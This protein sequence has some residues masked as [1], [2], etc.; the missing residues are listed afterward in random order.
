MDHKLS[1]LK[2]GRNTRVIRCE[3]FD[4]IRNFLSINNASELQVK[5]IFKKLVDNER[6]PTDLTLSNELYTNPINQRDSTQ[7]IFIF[8]GISLDLTREKTVDKIRCAHEYIRP[9]HTWSILGSGFQG[10]RNNNYQPF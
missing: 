7:W 9:F 6:I 8:T 4:E 2:F 3:R 10:R 5:N 1:I